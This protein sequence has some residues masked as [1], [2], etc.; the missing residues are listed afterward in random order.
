MRNRISID[1]SFMNDYTGLNP[2]VFLQVM[3]LYNLILLPIIDDKTYNIKISDNIKILDKTTDSIL[4]QK[5]VFST[6]QIQLDSQN[7]FYFYIANGIPYQDHEYALVLDNTNIDLQ[8][9]TNINS[10]KLLIGSLILS[11]N[12]S[13]MF[14]TNIPL[15]ANIDNHY[16][17]FN[18]NQIINKYNFYQGLTNNTILFILDANN[19]EILSRI[20]TLNHSILIRPLYYKDFP[21]GSLSI[22]ISN[23][24]GVS[25]NE[26]SEFKIFIN[27]KSYYINSNSLNIKNLASN[28]YTIKIIDR[29][30]LLDIDYLNGQLLNKD[31]FT[32]S[33]PLIK[34]SYKLDKIALPIPRDYKQPSA[35]R[36][37]LMINLDHNQPF[38]LLGPNN[39]YKQ[40]S[41]G[42]QSLYNIDSGNYIIKYN[43]RLQSFYVPPNEIVNI[44]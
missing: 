44:P 22:N 10:A 9:H 31:E 33:I 19:F 39:F 15:L 8:T 40:Y 42:Y 36:A 30:G 24:S 17:K 43:D 11:D 21:L 29:L 41:S 5:V 3:R 32:I 28:K 27:N 4:R 6:G 14:D 26:I 2:P 1:Y 18:I 12:Y 37:N 13:Y 20:N 7:Y 25:N 34:D 23:Y 16:I 38:E 35:E